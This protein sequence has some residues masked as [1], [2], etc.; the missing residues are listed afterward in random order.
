VKADGGTSVSVIVPFYKELDL[1]ER[2]VSS[3][4]GQVLPADVDVAVIIGNDSEWNEDEIRAVLSTP[5]NRITTIV[6]NVRAK[7]A[8]N[9]RNA[10]IDAQRGDLIAFLDADDY[11]LPDKLAHQLRLF[12]QGANLTSGAYRFE[13]QTNVVRPPKRLVSTR[14]LLMNLGV[15]MSTVAVSR[16]FLGDD[17][18]TNLQFSQDTELLARLAGKPGLR[19]ASTDEVVTVYAPS[20][21]TRNK[22]EQL[23]A[24]RKVVGMFHL[25]P[26]ERAVILLRYSVRGVV[27][28]YVRG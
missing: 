17:R 20:R 9:A 22:L 5:S 23:L 19:F 6:K 14:D 3:V 13:G 25:S 11:W 16:D 21:R 15:G 1:I 18:F 10:A 26:I 7:G 2:A 28:H 27:N 8:G 12:G 24:F 4:T